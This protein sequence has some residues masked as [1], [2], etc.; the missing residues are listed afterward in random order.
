MD[1]CFSTFR[2]DELEC[3]NRLFEEKSGMLSKKF[4]DNSTSSKI[5]T[6]NCEHDISNRNFESKSKIHDGYISLLSTT[7]KQTGFRIESTKNADV[8]TDIKLSNCPNSKSLEN[9][10]TQFGK[11]FRISSLEG[12]DWTDRIPSQPCRLVHAYSRSTQGTSRTIECQESVSHLQD[13]EKMNCFSLASNN[14]LILVDTFEKSV[15][16][17]IA[18]FMSCEALTNTDPKELAY[19]IA[20]VAELGFDHIIY[21]G[22]AEYGMLFLD[23]YSRVFLWEDSCQM[24][25]PLGDSPEEVPK[26]PIEDI[27]WFLENGTVCEYT[28]EL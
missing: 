22:E 10:E 2:G 21:I 9:L 11:L 6:S 26:H 16:S 12:Y 4:D 25:Y 28:G 13:C 24:V 17:Q 15:R 20:N 19:Y 23:C 14:S 7:D 1:L 18:T 8:T 5:L 3:A 27:G